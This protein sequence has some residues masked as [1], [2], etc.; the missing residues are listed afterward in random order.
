MSVHLTSQRT[1]KKHQVGPDKRH[2]VVHEKTVVA[3][4]NVVVDKGAVVVEACHTAVAGTAV[5]GAQRFA[6]LQAAHVSWSQQQAE[7]HKALLHKALL[8]HRLAI[9]GHRHITTTHHTRRAEGFGAEIVSFKQLHD[10]F[11]A[12]GWITGDNTWV[13]R[14]GLQNQPRE[15]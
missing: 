2:Q 5:L 4:P 3:S 13:R 15:R 9:A 10:G 12:L 11:V 14:V 1:K 8:S 6:C 7:L